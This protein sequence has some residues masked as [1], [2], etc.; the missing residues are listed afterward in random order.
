MSTLSFPFLRLPNELRH[1][2]YRHL[3]IAPHSILDVV[4]TYAPEQKA[5][6]IKLYTA[7]DASIL[8]TSREI[9]REASEV[10]YRSNTFT[11]LLDSTAPPYGIEGLYGLRTFR[12]DLSRARKCHIMSMPGYYPKTYLDCLE[13]ARLRCH[14]EKLSTD[15]LGNMHYLLI[16]SYHFETAGF[17]EDLALTLSIDDMLEPL[18]HVRSIHHVYIRLM[19]KSLISYV[20]RLEHSMM[21]NEG[22][23][24]RQPGNGLPTQEVDPRYEMKA[25]T[26]DDG[27]EGEEEFINPDDP[28]PNEIFELFGMKPLYDNTDF[29][30]DCK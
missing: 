24:A 18:R 23:F 3:L 25:T 10:F 19:K 22:S 6:Q 27:T 30:R 26:Y 9:R 20:R 29:L 14:L 13:A 15:V 8:Q 12:I 5:D 16:E 28:Y 1:L 2:I 7:H 21:D 4:S 17:K 11:I